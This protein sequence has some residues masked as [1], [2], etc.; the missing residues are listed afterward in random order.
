MKE[1]KSGRALS[2]SIAIALI[3]A[4]LVGM[5]SGS[6]ANTLVLT[7]T[8][9]EGV[10]CAHLISIYRRAFSATGFTF[11][12][13][14][15]KTVFDQTMTR[16]EFHFP[17]SEYRGKPPGAVSFVFISRLSAGRPINT[18]SV[19]AHGFG[20]DSESYSDEEW[21]LLIQRMQSAYQAAMSRVEA[22][23]GTRVK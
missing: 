5:T 16:I 17:V 18:C 23:T 4:W 10:D 9:Y 1:R 3:I 8:V 12:G 11:A 22:A 7:P 6:R 14:S 15:V 20:G 2:T 19:E 13:R 21:D